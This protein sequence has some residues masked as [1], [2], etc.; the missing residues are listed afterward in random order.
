MSKIAFWKRSVPKFDL[1][2]SKL[3]QALR[4]LAYNYESEETILPCIVYEKVK[5]ARDFLREDKDYNL[6]E[7]HVNGI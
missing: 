4:P 6:S 7:V 5:L 2:S 3:Y 1:P